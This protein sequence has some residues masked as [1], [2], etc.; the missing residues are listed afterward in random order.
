MTWILTGMKE[1]PEQLALYM[2]DAMPEQLKKLL[3]GISSVPD[4]G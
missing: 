3:N 1:A 2:T 4:E